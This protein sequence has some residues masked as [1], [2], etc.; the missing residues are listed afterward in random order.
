[1]APRRPRLKVAAKTVILDLP[2]WPGHTREEQAAI[3]LLIA[4][5]GKVYDADPNIRYPSW[6]EQHPH[7]KFMQCPECMT[8]LRSTWPKCRWCGFREVV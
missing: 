8:D 1:M 3:E 4:A 5:F 7:A 6:R 2:P